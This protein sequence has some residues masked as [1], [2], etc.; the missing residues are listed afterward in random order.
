VF[1]RGKL[2][3]LLPFFPLPEQALVLIGDEAAL[4]VLAY[5]IPI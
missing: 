4:L 2:I 5:V 3:I 1:R